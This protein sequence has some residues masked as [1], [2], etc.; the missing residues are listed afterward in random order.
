M[1]RTHL[2]AAVAIVC[3]SLPSFALVAHVGP[4]VGLNLAN[5]WGK[6]SRDN[7]GI[8]AG[9]VA[10]ITVPLEIKPHLYLEPEIHFSMKGTAWDS[11]VLDENG[12]AFE[13]INYVEIPVTVK[14]SLPG[15]GDNLVKPF[16]YL[17]PALGLR[18]NG[19]IQWNRSTAA[20]NGTKSHYT[21]TEELNV[22]D[23][24]IAGGGA[25]HIKLAD[26]F[27]FLDVRYSLGLLKTDVSEADR[28][29]W[30]GAV[31]L[32]YVFRLEKKEQLW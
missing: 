11:T 19:Y 1:K 31:T 18:T 8:L 25:V 3:S 2:Y 5:Q 22:V 26:G 10:G 12:D 27:F 24:S 15:M 28:K 4:R 16:L 29:N 7:A 14:F 9:L 17:G 6:D 23:L 20:D 32:G 21:L 13:R 30:C